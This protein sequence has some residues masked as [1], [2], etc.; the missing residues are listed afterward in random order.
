MLGGH[1]VAPFGK[2]Q[3][4]VCWLYVT[5]AWR[6][7]A[8]FSSLLQFSAVQG[9]ATLLHHVFPGTVLPLHWPK[10]TRTGGEIFKTMNQ[11]KRTTTKYFVFLH[12]L[13]F[14]LT[15]ME[16]CLTESQACK[17][18]LQSQAVPLS[19]DPTL[20]Q[21]LLLLSSVSPL[22]EAVM[23]SCSSIHKACPWIWGEKHEISEDVSASRRNLTWNI[24]LHISP[25]AIQHLND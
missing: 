14:L 15:T 17:G 10:S 21:I 5:W 8:S 7:P 22:L 2:I 1:P 3:L 25:H 6:D 18:G 23:S 4:G 11:N 19:P 20:T 9:G 13:Y 24:H 16:S 12:Y